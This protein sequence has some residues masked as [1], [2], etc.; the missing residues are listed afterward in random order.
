MR[1]EFEPLGYKIPQKQAYDW[2]IKLGA[3]FSSELAF[4]VPKLSIEYGYD[5]SKTVEKL[6]IQFEGQSLE[7]VLSKMIHDM[8]DLGML[9]DRRNKA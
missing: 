8:I 2:V 9:E 3:L 5:N 6:G 7:K 4:L 1:D